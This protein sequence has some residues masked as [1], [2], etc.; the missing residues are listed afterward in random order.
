MKNNKGQTL[1]AFVLL[2]P[3]ILLFLVIII[4]MGFSYIEK[5]RASNI[6]KD[7]ISYGLDNIEEDNI[8]LKVRDYIEMNI[9]DI[10]SLVV[11]EKNKKISVELI[12]NSKNLIGNISSENYQININ[13]E[14][15]IS[16]GKKSISRK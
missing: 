14:G 9:D 15:I 6:V 3:I 2:L 16:N 7:S 1:V 12:I 11:D 13:Y 5:R 8:S 10:S 4:N